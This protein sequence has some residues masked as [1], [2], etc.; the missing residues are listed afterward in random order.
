[1]RICPSLLALCAFFWAA[2]AQAADGVIEINQAD[3]EAAGGFPYVISQP[4]SYI[5]TGNLT[6]GDS[7]RDGVE[8][9]ADHVTLDLNGFVIQGAGS[10][11]GTGVSSQDSNI[12]RFR[13]D[14]HVRNGSVRNFRRG[15]SLGSGS[16]ENVRAWTNS[17]DGISALSGVALFGKAATTA[18]LALS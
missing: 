6:L 13:N 8:I 2:G 4:G 17:G 18:L 16:V 3:V 15:V 7:D 12:E 1:M 11:E 10:G 14:V 5:L 9:E